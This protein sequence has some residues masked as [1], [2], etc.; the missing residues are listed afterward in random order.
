MIGRRAGVMLV[1]MLAAGA[2]HLAAQQGQ[3]G[4]MQR[5]LAAPTL[6]ELKAALSLDPDQ[7]DKVGKILGKWGE[8]TKGARELLMANFQAMQSGGDVEALRAE[9]MMAMQHIRERSEEMNTQIRGVLTPEQSKAFDAFI[10]ER[11]QRMRQGRPGG[12]PPALP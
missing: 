9:S 1:A 11:M 6:E 10:A 8:E 2:G 12:P 7:S 3:G 4:G 5:R